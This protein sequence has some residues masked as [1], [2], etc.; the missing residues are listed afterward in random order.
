MIRIRKLREERE[1]KDTVFFLRKRKV[2]PENIDRFA[3][4]RKRGDGEASPVSGKMARF[5][6]LHVFMHLS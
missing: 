5:E 1:G 2:P 4:R 6:C 3:K